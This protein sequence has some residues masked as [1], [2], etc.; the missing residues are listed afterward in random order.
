MSFS[1]RILVIEME[2]DVGNGV[3][4]VI[5]EQ[6]SQDE[7]HLLKVCSLPFHANISLIF[8]VI[9]ASKQLSRMSYDFA[10][11]VHEPEIVIG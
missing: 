5:V 3:G 1:M 10:E 2:N 8:Q 6:H 11:N 7:R 4:S 9:S